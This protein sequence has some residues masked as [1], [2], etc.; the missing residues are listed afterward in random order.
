MSFYFTLIF[1]SDSWGRE[2]AIGMIW[3]AA[4]TDEH[5]PRVF[6][7]QKCGNFSFEENF[8][9][10]SKIMLRWF[11]LIS[12]VPECSVNHGQADLRNPLL[13]FEL[14]EPAPEGFL[15]RRTAWQRPHEGLSSLAA[16]K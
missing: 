16:N 12:P 4:Q 15:E 6:A 14:S 7:L 9:A 5:R 2:T 1:I 10:T 13:N 8:E 3:A 11:N